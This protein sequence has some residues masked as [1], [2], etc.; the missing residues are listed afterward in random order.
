MKDSSV[1]H[2]ILVREAMLDI[3]QS[4]R[5]MKQG[6]LATAVAAKNLHFGTRLCGTP[7]TAWSASLC[8]FTRASSTGTRATAQL[9]SP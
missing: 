7:S 3:L 1:R 6:D 8:G 5:R 2:V 9:R 4:G